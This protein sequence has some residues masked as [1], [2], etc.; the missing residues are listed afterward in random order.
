MKTPREKYFHDANFRTLVDLM[1]SH[2]TQCNYTPSE[3]RQAAILASI[4]YEEMNMR[5][6]TFLEPKIQESLNT[7]HNWMDKEGGKGI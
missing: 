4:K 1:V 5:S 2:I 7:I 6:P 3:M